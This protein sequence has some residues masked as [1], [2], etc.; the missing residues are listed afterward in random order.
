MIAVSISDAVARMAD[1]FI[2][3]S[4]CSL[5]YPDYFVVYNISPQLQKT[6]DG[7]YKTGR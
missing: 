1:R 7:E 4:F 3:V 2:I 6:R 5:P